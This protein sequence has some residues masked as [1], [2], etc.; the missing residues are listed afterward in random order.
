MQDR[1][2][3]STTAEDHEKPAG[4]TAKFHEDNN[5]RS[6]AVQLESSKYLEPKE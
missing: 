2:K 4:N 6:G 1:H 5:D 3:P